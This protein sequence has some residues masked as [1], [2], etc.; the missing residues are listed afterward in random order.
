MAI[1]K[2]DDFGK[3]IEAT[4]RL[5]KYS[6]EEDMKK[7]IAN[8][9]LFVNSNPHLLKFLCNNFFNECGFLFKNYV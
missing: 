4:G 7:I 8:N 5:P 9:L 2:R 1:I 3:I 6:T